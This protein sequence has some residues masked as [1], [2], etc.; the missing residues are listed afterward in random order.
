MNNERYYS[1]LAP[2]WKRISDHAPPINTKILLRTHY[3]VAL[4]GQYYSEGNFTH[5]CGLPKL[6]KEEKEQLKQCNQSQSE[7]NSVSGQ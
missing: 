3:G 5:W 6:S 7:M 4:I 2:V 1:E